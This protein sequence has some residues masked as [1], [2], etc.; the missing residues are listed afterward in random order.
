MLFPTFFYEPRDRWKLGKDCSLLLDHNQIHQ[1]RWD[2]L[3]RCCL[4]HLE[5]KNDAKSSQS[6]MNSGWKEQKKS[7]KN[8]QSMHWTFSI[9]WTSKSDSSSHPIWQ[10]PRS[11]P[12]CS[13]QN[14]HCQYHHRHPRATGSDWN[15]GENLAI[16]SVNFYTFDC[17]SI[18][19]SPCWSIGSSP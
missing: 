8:C 18:S 4:F 5:P 16:F 9:F 1:C 13:T 14:L 11:Y 3:S 19:W 6:S 10:C 15:L 17:F 2:E 12:W 7:R